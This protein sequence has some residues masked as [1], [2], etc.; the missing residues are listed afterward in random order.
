MVRFLHFEIAQ[1]WHITSLTNTRS[2]NTP[3][4][5]SR[6][7]GGRAVDYSEAIFILL[8]KL[9]VINIDVFDELINTENSES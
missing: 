1:S 9:E 2:S 6:C 7:L 5:P 3:K 8:P 4:N